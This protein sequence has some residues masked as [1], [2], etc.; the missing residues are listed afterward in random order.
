VL[1]A[2]CPVLIDV[3]LLAAERPLGSLCEGRPLRRI[4]RVELARAAQA[5][6]SRRTGAGPPLAGRVVQKVVDP[7]HGVVRQVRQVDVVADA[8]GALCAFQRALLIVLLLCGLTAR[9][10][11]EGEAND[12]ES[13]LLRQSH[14]GVTD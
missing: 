10:C 5:G 3:D 12:G 2:H 6:R 14:C 13:L 7:R 4:A 11:Q 9:A 1:S 8:L